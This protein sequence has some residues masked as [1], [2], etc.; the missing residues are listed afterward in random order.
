MDG[1]LIKVISATLVL[2]QTMTGTHVA[3][4]SR[5]VPN[6]RVNGV[7]LDA[8]TRAHSEA[9]NVTKRVLAKCLLRSWIAGAV[10]FMLYYF[11]NYYIEVASL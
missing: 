10:V 4:P 11:V 2:N 8:R 6:C 7:R 9:M 3:R 1:P 5:Y